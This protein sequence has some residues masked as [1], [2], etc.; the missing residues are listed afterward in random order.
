MIDDSIRLSIVVPCYNEEKVLSEFY[1]RLSKVCSD[2]V[3]L[4]EDYEI[5]FINDGSTDLTWE[6]IYKICKENK[7]VVGVNL[8]RNFGH[9]LALTAGLDVACG[10]RIFIIDADL[11]DPPELLP[12]FMKL[13]DEGADVV[14]GKREHRVGETFFKKKSASIFYRLLN[15]MAK[16]DIP[17]DT[18]DFRLITKRVKDKLHSMPENQRFLR[19]M[20]SWIGFNQVPLNYTRQPRFAGET[21]YPLS[22]MVAFSI[23]AITGF[24]VSP[25]RISVYFSLLF[26][27]IAILLMIYV[28]FSW[29]V[30]NAVPGWASLGVILT[31]LGAGQFLVMA[32]IGEYISRIYIEAKRRPLYIIKEIIAME[33]KR[34][35]K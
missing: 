5:I 4:N 3:F 19:G 20:I 14:Y 2:Q 31:L 33:N 9:Q 17:L 7:H 26:S 1:Q 34:T 13:M 11:Q 24:S 30:L 35:V 15:K 29:T 32:I 22:K 18:G 25:I 28:I 16:I 8:S 23:D 6:I 21:K 27:I 10:E 12:E